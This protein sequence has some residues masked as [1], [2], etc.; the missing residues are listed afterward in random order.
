MSN[1]TQEQLDALNSQLEELQAELSSKQTEL[2]NFEYEA[3]D[4]EYDDFLDEVNPDISIGSL[5]Y[6]PSQVL[7]SV[8]PVAYR[9]GKSE[10]EA[11]YDLGSCEEYT[12]LQEEVE[13]L[14]NQIEDLETEICD[15]ENEL[16][17]E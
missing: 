5:T 16:T 15:L 6:S 4:D 1:Y 13:D 7:K 2:E 8:D 12:D 14:E 11:D 9:C 10:Y 17:G 3:T